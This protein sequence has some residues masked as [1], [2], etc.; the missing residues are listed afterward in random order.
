MQESDSGSDA[1]REAGLA[2][3][4]RA[5]EAAG[6]IP[7]EARP[8]KSLRGK[9]GTQ[10]VA[11]AASS[12]VPVHRA[13]VHAEQL[14][15]SEELG[16]ELKKKRLADQVA[17]Q[18]AQAALEQEREKKDEA[19][20]VEGAQMAAADRARMGIPEPTPKQPS[21]KKPRNKKQAAVDGGGSGV[22]GAVEVAMEVDSQLQVDVRGAVSEPPEP[23]AALQGPRNLGAAFATGVE[24]SEGEAAVAVLDQ[25]DTDVIAAGDTASTPTR[26]VVAGFDAHGTAAGCSS[27][28]DSL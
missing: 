26:G 5:Q 14:K 3:R 8:T 2:D 11:T 27:T 13:L 28:P 6:A 9:D 15:R 7:V 20:L 19:A 4:R 10:H 17:R 25:M 1:D 16:S 18:L 22:G 12:T 23:Q 24:P 21:K